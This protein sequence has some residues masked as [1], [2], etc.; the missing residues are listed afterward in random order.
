MKRF[1][2]AA[3][4]VPAFSLAL[5]ADDDHGVVFSANLSTFNEVPPK[6]NGANGLFGR[7]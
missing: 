2:L 5:T 6:A 7:S 1:L 4:L 3:L